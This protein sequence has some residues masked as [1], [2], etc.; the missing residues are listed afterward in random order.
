MDL[1]IA[2]IRVVV[3]EVIV[4]ADALRWLV[5]LFRV[6]EEA[7]DACSVGLATATGISVWLGLRFVYW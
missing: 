1:V 7:A 2:L 5:G 6:G 4:S 3:S